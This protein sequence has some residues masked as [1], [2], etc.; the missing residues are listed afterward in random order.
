MCF[1]NI[2]FTW[3]TL[4]RTPPI[5]AM[6]KVDVREIKRNGPRGEKEQQAPCGGRRAL[7]PLSRRSRGLPTS[8]D[9]GELLCE[10]RRRAR[11]APRRLERVCKSGRRRV[12]FAACSVPE[13]RPLPNGLS[14]TPP[15]IAAAQTDKSWFH[16][17]G[18]ARSLSVPRRKTACLLKYPHVA[19][20][21]RAECL[22]STKCQA[23]S[24]LPRS[25]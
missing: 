9:P 18:D 4:F 12:G 22:R 10:R 14:K 23:S 2:F 6:N 11:G 25:D 8:Y 24:R 20:P 21:L 17:R 15:L 19:G 1:R 7:R 16:G 5:D 13:R 3:T